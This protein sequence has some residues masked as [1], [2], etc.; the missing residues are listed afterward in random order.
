[1]SRILGGSNVIDAM[2]SVSLLAPNLRTL[3]FKGHLLSNDGGPAHA[4]EQY[5]NVQGRYDP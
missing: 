1:M 3:S 5:P 2:T 4:C